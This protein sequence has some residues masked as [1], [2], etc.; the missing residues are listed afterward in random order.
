MAFKPVNLPPVRTDSPELNKWVDLVRRILSDVVSIDQKGNIVLDNDVY[1]RSLYVKDNSVYIGGVKLGKPK[2]S[3]DGYY[4]KYSKADKKFTY[5][6]KATPI[7]E[8]VQDI[9]GAMVTGNTE[10]FI[11]V[12]YEDSDGTL[13]FVVPVKNED[14]MASDSD[15][16]L[17]TQQSIKAYVDTVAVTTQNNS[18]LF[19]FFMS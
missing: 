1:C 10:T 19:A 4:L 18:E 16:F 13:D 3:E 17:A 12:T 9:V 11:T 7:D 6:E 15:T 8:A 5:T 2:N 14:D